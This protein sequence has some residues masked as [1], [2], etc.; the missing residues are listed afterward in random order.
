MKISKNVDTV[1]LYQ[2]VN[3]SVL[4]QGSSF[5]ITQQNTEIPA[6][7]FSL[8]INKLPVTNFL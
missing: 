7:V 1:C 3:L 4:T 8:K 2:C 5:S 6:D